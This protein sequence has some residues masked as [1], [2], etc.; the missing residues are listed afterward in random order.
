MLFD[1]SMVVSPSTRVRIAVDGNRPAML[2][3]DGRRVAELAVGDAV[4]CSASP[5]PFRFV[6][7]GKRRFHQ[8]LK[9]KFG[10]SGPPSR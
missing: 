8:V 6:T 3:V 2:S 10:L 4:E 7:F 9:T 5:H 1:R